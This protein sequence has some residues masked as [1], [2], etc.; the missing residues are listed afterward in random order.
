MMM[1]KASLDLMVEEI[2]YSIQ[3]SRTLLV[4]FPKF[5]IKFQEQLIQFT[6]GISPYVWK[7]CL[8]TVH[9]QFGTSQSQSNIPI[10]VYKEEMIR[11]DIENGEY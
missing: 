9:H 8:P 7:H 2:A 3:D 11:N 5:Y 1:I 4:L 6:K 10:Q